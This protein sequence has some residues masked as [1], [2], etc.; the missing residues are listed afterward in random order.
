MIYHLCNAY[1]H[2]GT[3]LGS[4]FFKEVQTKVFTLRSLAGLLVG[5]S[6]CKHCPSILVSI[7][8]L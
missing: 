2:P 6:Y 1:T 4:D 3:V 5:C 7:L 8:V